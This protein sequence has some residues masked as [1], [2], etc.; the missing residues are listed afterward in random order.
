MLSF[1]YFLILC[2]LTTGAGE[3]SLH[4][5][6]LLLHSQLCADVDSHKRLYII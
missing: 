3:G 4:S 6:L 2:P 5:S 1:S